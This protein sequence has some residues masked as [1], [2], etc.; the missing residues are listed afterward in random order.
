MDASG[1]DSTHSSAKHPGSPAALRQRPF[2]PRRLPGFYGFWVLG[3]GTL[4]MLMS[5]PGQTIGVSVF[6]DYL[7][8]ELALTR[9][10]LSLAYLLGTLGSALALSWAGRLYDRFGG[11]L[12][13]TTAALLL[14]F[15][16]LGLTAAPDLARFLGGAVAAFG[17]MSVGFFLLRFSG[18]GML[19]LASRN[20]VMEW[21]DR[22]RGSANAVMGVSISFG[23]SYAPRVFDDLIG[24]AGWRAAWRDLA[25][26][27]VVFAVLAFLFYRDTPEAHGLAPD[28]PLR[29]KKRTN[30]PETATGRDFTLSE[31]RRSYS[32]WVFTLA[33]LLAGLVLTAYTFHIVSIFSDAGLSRERAVS[34][35]LPAAIVAVIV[36]FGGSWLSDYIKLKY[37]LMVQLTGIMVLT[38]SVSL[39]QP[40]AGVAGVILGQGLMQGVFGIL[41]NVTWPRFFGRG[42]LGAISGFVMAFTVVGTAVGPYVFSLGRDLTGSYG[43]PALLCAAVAL[44][45]LLAAGRANRPT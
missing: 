6:T 35:F 37:L 15:V 42:H 28:G 10:G 18:Q 8:E 4:G 38:V 44:A 24:I 36:E 32:F 13:A 9:T 7:L 23:F 20:M 45:L 2:N 16:L 26:A 3:F 43:L 14:S 30:H 33:L 29:S 19:T 1:S 34:V 22:R 12:V 31:A 41:S 27:M 21:F 39:L 25:V 5:A 40:G 17:V 11:R